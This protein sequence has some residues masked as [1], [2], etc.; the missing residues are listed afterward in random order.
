MWVTPFARVGGISSTRLC[1]E[2]SIVHNG[3]HG[4]VSAQKERCIQPDSSV[5]SCAIRREGVSMW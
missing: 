2:I 1:L 5:V 3:F 4:A